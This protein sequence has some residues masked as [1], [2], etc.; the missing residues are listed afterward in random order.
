MIILINA[1][2]RY[3][4]SACLLEGCPENMTCNEKTKKNDEDQTFPRSH[5]V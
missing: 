3:R 1:A 4:Q 2:A 5:Q